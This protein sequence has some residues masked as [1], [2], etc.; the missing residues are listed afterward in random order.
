M[1]LAGINSLSD[2]GVTSCICSYSFGVSSILKAL[3]S[4]DGRKRS[5]IESQEQNAELRGSWLHNIRDF[6]SCHLVYMG[7]PRSDKREGF[8]RRG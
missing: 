7:E 4:K 8:K 6:Q 3:N 2:K 5:P 1:R